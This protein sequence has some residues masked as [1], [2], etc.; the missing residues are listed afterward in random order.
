MHFIYLDEAGN[1]G[2]N[3]NDAVQ[4]IFVLG[5]LIV[6]EQKWLKLE[7]E[8]SAAIDLSF[9][10][11]RPDDFEVH[12]TELINARGYYRNFPIGKRLYFFQ[13]WLGIAQHNELVFFHRAIVKKRYAAW[14]ASTFGAGVN[15][16]P[17]VA[18][19]SLLAQVVD[20]YLHRLPG[21]PLGIFISDENKQVV[22]DVEKSIRLLRGEKGP[23][24]LERIVEKGF[25][26]ES[27]KS[28]PLQLCDLCT[29]AVRRMEEA[30]AG[31]PV[32]PLDKDLIPWIRPLIHHGS[33][34]LPDV[35]VWLQSQQKEERPGN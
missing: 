23:L 24:R 12:G 18:A 20:D 5:A 31:M 4:P 16:N 1:T 10:P 35:L 6:P 29:Y 28:L 33:E 14:L 34:P 3:L 30:K 11:P 15:I 21:A 7:A 22:G 8:L 26:I 19:F 17:H 13:S 27:D 32:K 9:P 2:N 25:F